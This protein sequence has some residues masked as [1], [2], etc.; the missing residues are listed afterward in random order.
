MKRLAGALACAAALAGCAAVPDAAPA[1]GDVDLLLLG[2]QHD[3]ASHQRLH[4]DTVSDLAR[5]GRLA[6]LALEMAERGAT[7]AGLPRDAS[8]DAVREALRWNEQGWP[9]ERYAPA[10]MAAVRAGVPVVGA[11]LPRDAMRAAM[12]D[13]TLDTL[14]PPQ[15]LEQQRSAMRSGHCGLLPETQ[16]APMARIQIARDRAMADTLVDLARRGAVAVLVAGS[17]HV[18]E[19]AGIPRHLPA[20]L[21][22]GTLAWPPE[23]PQKDYCAELRQRMRPAAR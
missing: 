12:A 22:V 1:P 2:E 15:V 5:S 18:D 3:A 11:N 8:E 7:T 16:V 20:T 17:A 14:L 13:A 4:R 9:W 10:V 19:I 6:A 21:R 23:P